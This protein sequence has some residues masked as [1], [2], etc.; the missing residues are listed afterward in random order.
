[1]RL[2]F[3][4]RRAGDEGLEV[5]EERGMRVLHLGSQAIQSAMRLSRPWDLELAYTR[6]MMGFLMFNS[7]PQDVLM[8]GL[9]GGS[10]AKFI[11]RQRPQTHLTA[12]E[13][14]PRVIAAA[15]SHC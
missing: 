6:A 1:M 2:K 12:V 15:R 8:I 7:T 11:R 5:T 13:I 10:L 9:G 3:G 4:K 14:D